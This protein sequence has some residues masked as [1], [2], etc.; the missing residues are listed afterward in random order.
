MSKSNKKRG[1]V[2]GF[3]N[4]ASAWMHKSGLSPYLFILRLNK[5][6]LMK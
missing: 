5:G 6:Y 4:A 1:D 3:T 2:Y